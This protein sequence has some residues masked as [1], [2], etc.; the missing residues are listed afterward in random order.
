MGYYSLTQH[1]QSVSYSII[2]HPHCWFHFH[3]SVLHTLR[4]NVILAK[5]EMSTTSSFSSTWTYLFFRLNYLCLQPGNKIKFV[6]VLL[7]LKVFAP[8]TTTTSSNQATS[9]TITI[10]FIN[11]DGGGGSANH[12]M[13]VK[14]FFFFFITNHCRIKRMMKITTAPAADTWYK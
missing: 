12:L 8:H 5:A 7:Y 11:S 4:K 6:P 13:V 3:Y 9:A 1:H 14:R 10:I 2:I